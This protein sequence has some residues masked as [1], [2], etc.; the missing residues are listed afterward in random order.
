MATNGKKS[1]RKKIIIFSVLGIVIVALAIIVLMGSKKE[2]IISVQ[3]EKVARRTITQVVTATGKIQ[4]E[5]KVDISPEVSGEIVS[6][7]VKEGYHVKKGDLLMKIK[8]D[9][10]IAQRN[11]FAAAVLQ[12][13]STLG[14]TQPDFQR[15][16]ALFKKGLISQSD[17]DQSRAAYE[18]AKAS[19]AQAQASLD[20]AEESLRKTTVT[21]PMDGTVSQLNSE[22]GERVLG[23]QQFQGTN[24]MT[25]ADLTR[26]EAQVDVSE[27][28]VILVH[29][30]DTARVAVD[31]I[32]DRK[33]N[34]VVYEI[35]NT[36]TT[37]GAGTQEEVTNFTVKMRVLDKD[38]PL[39]PG[40]SMTADIECQTKDNVLCVPIQSVTTRM[41][42]MEMKEG[43]GDQQSGQV[44][45][46]STTT[47]QSLRS[48]AENK[49]KEIVFVVE[50]GVA[51]A[52]PVKRGISNDSYVE[53]VQGPQEGA[54]VVSG[55][56]KAIN[57]E[58]EDGSKVKVEE[59]KKPGQTTPN[60]S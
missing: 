36:G 39:R 2:P 56:Y 33:V 44:T 23:T 40:M 55:S 35:A 16:E 59:A 10:Y 28:D 13:K 24:V 15:S 25:I 19:Y 7:P 22:L 57:R 29:I 49:P 21:A 46:T 54:Q 26:M 34:A 30:G 9:V 18:S 37:T 1:K 4:P 32:P 12:A 11:Q 20:Q 53:L 17:F 31:A 50:N 27:N 8:P 48:R 6:L 42:K 51:K 45:T 52:V 38:V 41:P 47:T 43:Q 60:P 5:V 3:V 58:I 14:K